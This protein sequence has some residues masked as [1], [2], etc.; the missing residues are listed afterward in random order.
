MKKTYLLL[1]CGLICTSLGCSVLTG[2]GGHSNR[3]TGDPPLSPDNASDLEII[4]ALKT[5]ADNPNDPTAHEQLAD[6]FLAR[7]WAGRSIESYEQALA[8]QPDRSS[9]WN[10]LAL[11][12]LRVHDSKQAI[13]SLGQALELEPA[14]A[15][16]NYNLATAY[17]GLGKFDKALH[18]YKVALIA[19]PRLADP[20]INPNRYGSSLVTA[21][22]ISLYL[23]TTAALALEPD[24]LK[25]I[26]EP[27]TQP[28]DE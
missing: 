22:Q 26:I 23:D 6:A 21:A 16:A 4:G 14:D 24:L 1:A 12:Q 17:E 5:A 9:T 11:A 25:R 19:D 27:E 13:H 20:Q 10:K 2:G 18:H 7:G 28:S 3:M 8:L 15:E